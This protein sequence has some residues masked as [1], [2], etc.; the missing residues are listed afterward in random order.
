VPL[1]P[2]FSDFGTEKQAWLLAVPSKSFQSDI[3]GQTQAA[4]TRK[5]F[6]RF[7]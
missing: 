5:C 7:S 4:G 2:E 6:V 1:S 3:A